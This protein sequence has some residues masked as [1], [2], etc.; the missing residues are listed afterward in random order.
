MRFVS[1]EDIDAAPDAEALVRLLV[2][3]DTLLERMRERILECGPAAVPPLL[4]LLEDPWLTLKSSREE[5]WAQYYAIHLLGEL[6][7]VEAFASLLRILM[8]TEWD[9]NLHDRVLLALPRL[10]PAILEPLLELYAEGDYQVRFELRSVLAE[11]G[12]RDDRI[13]AILVK[14]VTDNLDYGVGNLGSYGDPRALPL[15]STMLDRYQIRAGG[16]G[17]NRTVIEINEAIR[18]L[19]G[20]LTPAQRAKV[21]RVRN[22]AQPASRQVISQPERSADTGADEP[23]SSRAS[24]RPGASDSWGAAGRPRWNRRPGRRP[25]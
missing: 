23:G 3:A 8:L 6:G 5:S 12:A 4:A 9:D 7:A 17:A 2:E 15:L 20:E 19:D 10:G 14:E 24:R 21:E 16:L 22:M 18:E 11:L 25:Y 1:Q 13:Y